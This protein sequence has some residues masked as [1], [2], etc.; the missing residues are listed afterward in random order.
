MRSFFGGGLGVVA[1]EEEALVFFDLEDGL[2]AVAVFSL[3]DLDLDLEL[4]RV[5]GLIV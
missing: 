3:S 2:A 4:A 1:E 5:G